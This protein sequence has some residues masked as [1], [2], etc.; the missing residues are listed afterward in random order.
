MTKQAIVAGKTEEEKN[1]FKKG[2]KCP[3]CND[4]IGTLMKYRHHCRNC[5]K[6]F[7]SGCSNFWIQIPE[8]INSPPKQNTLWS[9]S[10]YMDYF[11]L[12]DFDFITKLP[13]PLL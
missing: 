2:N 4:H 11:D 5:G 9:M 10:T 6:I 8:F 12:N 7:C 1:H 13:L 3:I